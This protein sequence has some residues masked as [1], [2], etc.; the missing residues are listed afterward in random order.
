MGALVNISSELYSNNLN[1]IINKKLKSL[2]RAS[3]NQEDNQLYL[4]LFY[5]S[6]VI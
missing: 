6:V 3:T 1:T 4:I 5:Y 2:K